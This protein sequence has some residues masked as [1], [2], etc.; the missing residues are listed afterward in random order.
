MKNI[1]FI[2][3]LILLVGCSKCPTPEKFKEVQDNYNRF[4]DEI[5][6]ADNTAR[7]ALAPVIQ[8]LQ[9]IRNDLNQIDLPGCM[10]AL[11]GYEARFYDEAISQYLRFMGGGNVDLTNVTTYINS[12]TTELNRL[13]S[14]SPNCK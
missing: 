6:I 3:V 10:Q 12:I 11:R 9:S 1:I 5:R 8:Q 13:T 14:C 2:L 4:Y 7:I